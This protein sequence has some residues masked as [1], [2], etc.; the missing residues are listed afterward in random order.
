MLEYCPGKW[1]EGVIKG[2]CWECITRL[3]VWHAAQTAVQGWGKSIW[4]HPSKN[5]WQDMYSF[6][7]W[8]SLFCQPGVGSSHVP[9]GAGGCGLPSS[10]PS[11]EKGISVLAMAGCRVRFIWA[12]RAEMTGDVVLY[13]Q[14]ES[15]ILTVCISWISSPES[16][17]GGRRWHRSEERMS[18]FACT[19]ISQVQHKRVQCMFRPS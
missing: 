13:F 9:R 10:P 11:S 15:H 5:H 17:E 19:R 7:L 14:G 2:Q 3:E 16:L 8:C 18:G 4:V 12:A 1:Q 6:L